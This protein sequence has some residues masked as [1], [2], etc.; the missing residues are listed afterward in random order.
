MLSKINDQGFRSSGILWFDDSAS[1]EQHL[2]GN[3][4]PSHL[5]HSLKDSQGKLAPLDCD[6]V[7]VNGRGSLLGLVPPDLEH[8][9]S[10]TWIAK[11]PLE[12]VRRAV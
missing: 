2:Y 3:K 7:V 12:G 9:C 8:S 1:R 10:L 11:D 5:F 4:E 6:Q